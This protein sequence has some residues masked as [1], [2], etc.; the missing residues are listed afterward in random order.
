LGTSL[1][2]GANANF[3]CFPWSFEALLWELSLIYSLGSPC[4]WFGI[5]FEA[6]CCM[7][8]VLMLDVQLLWRCLVELDCLA[9]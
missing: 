2:L 8:H 5:S 7:C 9:E 3:G 4:S 6:L 1:F